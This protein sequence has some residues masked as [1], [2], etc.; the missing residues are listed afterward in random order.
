MIWTADFDVVT[1]L[2]GAG[3]DQSV[4]E[5]RL[6]SIKNEIVFWWRAIAFQS[7]LAA[8]KDPAPYR[9]ALSRLQKDERL[10]FGDATRGQGLFVAALSGKSGDKLTANALFDPKKRPGVTYMGYGLAENCKN[11]EYVEDARFTLTFRFKPAV[12]RDPAKAELLKS[13]YRAIRMTGLIGAFGGRKR[14]GFGSLSLRAFEGCPY[15]DEFVPVVDAPDLKQQIAAL[16]GS[17]NVGGQ[18]WELSAFA[19]ETEIRIWSSGGFKSG[20]D[21]LEAAGNEFRTYRSWKPLL[22]NFRPDH[23]WF[24]SAWSTD[25]EHDQSKW[26]CRPNNVPERAAFGLPHNYFKYGKNVGLENL[27]AK[28]AP[29]ETDVE[30]RASPLIFRIARVGKIYVPVAIFFDN[31]FLP[32]FKNGT[33][34][35]LK[36]A[37]DSNV[38]YR[39][40]RQVILDFLDGAIRH[41]SAGSRGSA[42]N[43]PFGER[44]A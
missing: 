16:A 41:G 1:P 24:K 35:T 8:T 43:A 6:T 9:E 36:I 37:G 4:P 18:Q 20:Q 12:A 22:Y 40:E 33:V 34:G 38:K 32:N 11:R 2:F 26:R 3:N 39:Y 14:R 42:G 15:C 25:K 28:V 23:D 30:R 31:L 21:A 7:Y 27:K 17:R 19:K 44:V 29:S 10:L 13:L 5:I